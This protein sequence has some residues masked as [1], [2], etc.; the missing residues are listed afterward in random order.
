MGVCPARATQ[1]VMGQL[2][3]DGGVKSREAKELPDKVQEAWDSM[4]KN[5]RE[6]T[7][8]TVEQWTAIARSSGASKHGELVKLLKSK[9]GLTHGYANMVAMRTLEAGK[10]VEAG[11]DDG[12]A[13]Q[14]SGD[15]APLR[16]IYDAI[17]RAVSRFGRD[18]EI[19]P[20]KT[21]VSLRRGKQFAIIQ[22]ST[23]TRVDVGLNLGSIRPAGRLESSGSFNAMVSHR[24][25]LGSVRDVDEELIKWL[26]A[27]YDSA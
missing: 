17:V 2:E 22:P 8:K 4:A 12:V 9:H 27:A 13:M 7:G 6:K 18:V 23:S 10:G 24:V 19:S 21:W 3:L 1:S 15:K 14:Y 16:Q 11:G 5:L 20:K 26:R 25:R